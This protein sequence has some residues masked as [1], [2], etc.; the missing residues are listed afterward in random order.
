MTAVPAPI[1][2]TA[3]LVHQASG[4]TRSKTTRMKP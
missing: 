1:R 3:G 4:P 2:I